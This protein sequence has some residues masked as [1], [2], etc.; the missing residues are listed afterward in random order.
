ML[1]TVKLTKRFNGHV[2]VNELN[3]VVQPGEVFALLGPNRAGK[4]TTI[5]C[6][7][8]LLTPDSREAR[9][10]GASVSANPIAARRYLAYIPERVMLYPRFSGVDYLD[11]FST[12]GGRRHTRE[13][14]LALLKRAGLPV[15]TGVLSLWAWRNLRPASLGL[16]SS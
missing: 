10:N 1:E 7:H 6:L 11:Y 15:V 3:P 2:A 14:L 4:T 13:E 8:E 16:L 9:V 5:N 12:L